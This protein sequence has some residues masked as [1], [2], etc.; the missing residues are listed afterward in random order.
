MLACLETEPLPLLGI[1]AAIKC[2]QEQGLNS[3]YRSIVVCK[4]VCLR[5]TGCLN[6][7]VA[8]ASRG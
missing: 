7:P 1:M 5:H 4:F 6:A 2:C 8:K 3:Q